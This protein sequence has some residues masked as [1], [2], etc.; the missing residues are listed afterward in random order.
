MV[1]R[2]RGLSGL[3]IEAFDDPRRSAGM[4]TH[5]SGLGREETFLPKLTSS[6]IG[7]QTELDIA[8]ET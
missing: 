4:E 5:I 2:E 1:K 8:S 6:G 7:G 3:E